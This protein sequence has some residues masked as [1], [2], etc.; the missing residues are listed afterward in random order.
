MEKC[1]LFCIGPPSNFNIIICTYFKHTVTDTTLMLHNGIASA[2]TYI[3]I[4]VV[5]CYTCGSCFF[6][7]KLVSFMLVSF[8]EMLN[9]LPLTSFVLAILSQRMCKHKLGS[10]TCADT[11]MSCKINHRHGTI[12][13]SVLDRFSVTVSFSFISLL[14]YLEIDIV[15]SR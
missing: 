6:V 10:T 12:P 4:P 2:F 14:L 3:G 15:L 8:A 5:V 13:A 1:L 11:I 7:L 9:R